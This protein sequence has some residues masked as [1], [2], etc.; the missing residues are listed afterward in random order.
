MIMPFVS[1][2]APA[3]A[4][5]VVVMSLSFLPD[6]ALPDITAG[7]RAHRWLVMA[8]V[9]AL[10]G[11]GRLVYR[12]D[13]PWLA[14]ALGQ[15]LTI[16]AW[17]MVG[18]AL[19]GR[20]RHR[21]R[22]PASAPV[23]SKDARVCLSVMALLVGFNGLT[24]YLGL[25]F[26]YSF[27]M[28]SN[29]RVDDDRW[30]SFVFPRGFRLTAHDP[31]VHITRTRYKRLETGQIFE[32]GGILD[33]A[34]YSPDALRM[35]IARALSRGV[36]VTFDFEYQ[37]QHRSFA[38]AAD[39]QPLYALIADLPPAPLFQKVLDAGHPQSCEH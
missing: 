35:R 24:P 26:Q 30:N 12:G 25:K 11:G 21:D 15:S 33:P 39:P 29:L 14:T 2:G 34:L 32:S 28:L 1:I 27:A 6:E 18:F 7:L 9:I 5:L 8:S 3:F 16:V 36:Q 13:F 10:V 37:G 23:A 31:Y 17:W 4:G 19:R 38:E 20:L 22:W